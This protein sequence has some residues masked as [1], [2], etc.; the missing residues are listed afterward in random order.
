MVSMDDTA[1]FPKSLKLHIG[2]ESKA[3]TLLKSAGMALKRSKTA[4]HAPDTVR[5]VLKSMS[6][7]GVTLKGR[8]TQI[9]HNVRL[10]GIILTRFATEVAHSSNHSF[11]NY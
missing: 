4:L 7:T 5:E 1:I 6:L 10:P 3:L 11:F 9:N 2:H 8:E